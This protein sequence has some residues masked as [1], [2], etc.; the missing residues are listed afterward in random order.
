MVV[1]QI[2]SEMLFGV[3]PY[4]PVSLAAA[5]VTAALVASY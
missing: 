3:S 5:L 2:V 4:D 1:G